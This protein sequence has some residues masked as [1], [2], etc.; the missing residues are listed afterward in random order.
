MYAQLGKKNLLGTN[1]L[2][3]FWGG[4]CYFSPKPENIFHLKQKPDEKSAFFF[5]PTKKFYL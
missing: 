4:E 1:H 5:N 2:I 3:F